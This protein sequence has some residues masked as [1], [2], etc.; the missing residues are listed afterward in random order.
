MSSSP[1]SIIVRKTGKIAM[2]S[3]KFI[4]LKWS[5]HHYIFLSRTRPSPKEKFKFPRATEEAHEVLDGEEGDSEVVK[6]LDGEVDCGVRRVE[7]LTEFFG[8]LR[9]L[10]L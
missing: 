4:R 5:F 10:E 8:I 3:I 9:T 6:H 7:L 2:K 1:S